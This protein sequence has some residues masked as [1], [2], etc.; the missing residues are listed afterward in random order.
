MADITKIKKYLRKNIRCSRKA[1]IQYIPLSITISL[2]IINY[3]AFIITV[4]G[5]RSSL[6]G[7]LV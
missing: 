1:Y 2:Y 4:S 5:C 6:A 7:K 3:Y